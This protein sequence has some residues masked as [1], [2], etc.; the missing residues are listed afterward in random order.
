M[1]KLHFAKGRM[2]LPLTGSS[3]ELGKM[4]E[5]IDLIEDTQLAEIACAEACY[6]TADAKG[7][8]EHVKK[9][10]ASDDVMLRLSADMLYVFANLTLGNAGKAQAARI[11][12]KQCLQKALEEDACT[13]IKSSCIFAYYLINIFLHIETEKEMPALEGCISFSADR[14]E[15][16]CD[17]YFSTW[18]VF[19]K[20]ISESTRG[21]TD[22][23]ADG[24]CGLSDPVYLFKLYCGH[25][26]DQS[27]RAGGSDQFREESNFFC[28]KRR[29]F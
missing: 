16:V 25:V 24:R 26:P 3:Y 10:L 2:I 9:Y 11:D 23:N 20:R 27:K 21:R 15:T 29:T 22:C 17:Q 13:G 4:K 28:G 5:A 1:E 12:V 7:C 19:K 14:T 6:F 8:V 18:H